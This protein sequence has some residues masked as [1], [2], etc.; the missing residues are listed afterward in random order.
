MLRHEV[1]AECARISFSWDDVGECQRSEIV[2]LREVVEYVGTGASVHTDRHLDL[3]E[4][5]FVV[6]SCIR[7]D[8]LLLL[9]A[10][11]DKYESV[12]SYLF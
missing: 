7:C 5:S 11:D 10:A 12:E 8:H 3:V 6:P 1:W 9:A 4:G 2:R